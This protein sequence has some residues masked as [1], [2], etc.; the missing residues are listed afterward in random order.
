M[1]RSRR[2]DGFSKRFYH[3]LR[4]PWDQAVGDIPPIIC[5]FALP[6]LLAVVLDRLNN[7]ADLRQAIA[8][9]RA[10]LVP[11]RSEL[12]GFNEIVTQSTSQAEIDARIKRVLEAFDAVVPESRLSNVERRRRKLLTIQGL[13]RPLVKFA[14][15]FAMK[16]GATVEAG[17]GAAHGVVDA[18][19]ES[20]AI[21]DRT[22]TSQTFAG[23]LKTGPLQ[24]LV[25]TH[26]TRAEV[27]AL[28]RTLRR[29]EAKT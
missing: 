19:M 3:R 21:V 27:A 14:M 23:L 7:R 2:G 4:K 12:Q 26:F 15:G 18:V 1:V 16:S 13:V 9:L 22:I 5:T 17:I 20:R 24:G 6:P 25:E 10:E 29:R 8:D 11:V 28:E